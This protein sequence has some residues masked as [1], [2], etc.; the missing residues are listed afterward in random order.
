MK[1]KLRIFIAMIVIAIMA[2]TPSFA[3]QA[4]DS[5]IQIFSVAAVSG[6]VKNVKFEKF[7]LKKFRHIGSWLQEVQS[8]QSWV[9]QD[10]I[11]I[12]KRGGKAPKVLINNSVYPI[13]SN[14]REDT[15][16]VVSLNKYDTENRTVTDDELYA[17]AYDKEGDINLELKEE[18]EETTVNHALHSISP[19]E[20]TADTPILLTTGENDGTGRLRLTKKDLINLR[21]TLNK[22]KVPKK[23]RV[24]VLS[25]DHATDL[26][27]EDAGFE[28]G[29]HNRKEGVIS[30]NYYGFKIYEELYTPVYDGRTN[31][32][33]PFDSATKGVGSSI[34][35]HKKST[36]KAKGT[37]KRYA[38]PSSLNTKT[39]EA[40]LG[41]RMYF[42]CF[43]IQD[44][45][46]AAIIDGRKS[47]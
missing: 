17:I 10:V 42:G 27:M 45:G 30:E 38:I 35:F 8:K 43:A 36:A 2:V 9:N 20:E 24:L 19:K 5:G 12:P 25:S 34:V 32:I 22:L 44:V 29:Y 4:T 21:G 13:V 26:L 40:E 11:K 15:H 39:R 33:I 3:D 46:Q 6:D 28:K 41:Y 14:R 18:L 16:V 23:G 47:D 7:I 37:V 1:S 31:K